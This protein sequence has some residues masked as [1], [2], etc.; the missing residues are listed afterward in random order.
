MGLDLDV[1]GWLADWFGCGQ[2]R[3]GMPL[4]GLRGLGYRVMVAERMPQQ[5]ME[6][7]THHF[8]ERPAVI[9]GQRVCKPEPS[10]IWQRLAAEGFHTLVYEVDDDL[11]T[12]DPRSNPA[13]AAMYCDPIIATNIRRN[14]EV[15]DL[16]TVSTPALAKV[17]GEFNSN[18]TVLPNCIAEDLLRLERPVRDR[19]TLGWGGSFTHLMDFE[20]SG[21]QLRRWIDR[22]PQ[23]DFHCIGTDFRSHMK[24]PAERTRFT[25]WSP[26][27]D[28][29]YRNID[30]DIGLAPL[31]SHVFN[32]S[33]SHVKA[34]E[35][36]AL[37]IPAVVSAEPPYEGFVAHGETGYLVR[38][39][40]EWGKYISAL[41][42]DPGLRE[43]MGAKAKELAASY[44]IQAKAHL[45]RD[46]YGLRSKE[47]A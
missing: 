38:A 37:G 27:F 25:P 28:A 15:A 22:N 7:K 34:L 26:D 19:L 3:V 5:L 24:F 10:G 16:V 18:V 6:S 29:Y 33:K 45:W 14:V 43:S 46:A 8:L 41:A 47:A 4:W 17:F 39:P 44:T 30:F 32:R 13:G 21:P 2:Y 11:F 20:E 9:I 12:I 40:H 35:Y 31:K 1:F 42:R 36:A 23:A